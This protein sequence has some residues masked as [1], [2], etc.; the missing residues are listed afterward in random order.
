MA[1]RSNPL[2]SSGCQQQAWLSSA[3]A[4]SLTHAETI[5]IGEQIQPYF[6]SDHLKVVTIQGLLENP[7]DPLIWRGPV[8]IGI[9]RQ[10]L[11]DVNWGPLD[12]LIMDSPPG[13]GAESLTVA[14]TVTGCQAVIVTTPQ[15][16]ALAD[17]TSST[18]HKTERC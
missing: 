17:V 11:S 8:K 5:A 4:Q 13:T 1:K 14:Q 18:S 2:R 6:Y 12:F 9:I 7:D 16:I 10:F 3:K 15:E